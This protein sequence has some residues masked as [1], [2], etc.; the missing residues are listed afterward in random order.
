[1]MLILLFLVS[2]IHV[3]AN[4]QIKWLGVTGHAITDGKTTLLIDPV[5]NR[6]SVWKLLFFRSIKPDENLVIESL[7]RFGISKVDGIFISHTH[8]DHSIDAPV[9]IKKA[10]GVLYGS[11]STLNLGRGHKLREDQLKEIKFGDCS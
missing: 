11:S 5:F 10:G 2:L 6:P 1:M 9:I 4:V 8:H 7:K 3:Q